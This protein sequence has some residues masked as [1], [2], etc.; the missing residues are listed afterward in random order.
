MEKFNEQIM[1]NKLIN[2]NISQKTTNEHICLI[3]FYILY[4][5]VK[6]ISGLAH[7]GVTENE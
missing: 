5:T 1:K 2:V 6:K 7:L 3:Y 4:A